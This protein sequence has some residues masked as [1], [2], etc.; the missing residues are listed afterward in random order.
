MIGF[1]TQDWQ[2]Y[3]CINAE[4]RLVSKFLKPVDYWAADGTQYR[5]V[6]AM[7]DYASTPPEVWGPPFFLI[8]YGWWS[9]PAAGHDDAFQNRLLI[10]QTDGTTHLADLTE[11]ESNDLLDEMMQAIKPNPTVFEKAQMDAIYEG[12]TIGGFH[13]YK[14]DRT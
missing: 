13:S 14:V 9:L 2:S 8:P 12:V 3:N 11:R 10:V 6:G 1:S 5:I 4:N 7:T